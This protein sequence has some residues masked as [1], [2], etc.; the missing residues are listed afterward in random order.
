MELAVLLRA[1]AVSAD[2]YATWVLYL[3]RMLS[4]QHVLPSLTP[5]E[6]DAEQTGLWTGCGRNFVGSDMSHSDSH[7]DSSATSSSL[8]AEPESAEADAATETAHS[9]SAPAVADSA[10]K[11]RAERLTAQQEPQPLPWEELSLGPQSAG[12]GPA[13]AAAP[14][15]ISIGLRR[16]PNILSEKNLLLTAHK[17]P[18]QNR[19]TSAGTRNSPLL[20]RPAPTYLPLSLQPPL[21]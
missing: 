4:G 21:F 3:W 2:T 14:P 12:S 7:K 17:V 11:G 1:K 9:Q 15:L 13:A 20:P 8:A 16:D 18:N 19:W 5:P 6:G 10:R